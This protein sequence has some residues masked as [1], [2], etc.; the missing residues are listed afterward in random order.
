MAT[1]HPR[2]VA[3]EAARVFV[4]AA[5]TDVYWWLSEAV[6]HYLGVIYELKLAETR[7]RLAGEPAKAPLEIPLWRALL[8][9]M[10]DER[11]S[12]VSILS[13]L[14]EETADRIRRART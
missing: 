8:D 10:L 11:P 5:D 14:A 6:G 1:L 13:Q 2:R 3:W 12:E 4:T 9:E 7:L